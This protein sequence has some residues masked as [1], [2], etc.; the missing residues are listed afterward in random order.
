MTPRKWI[1]AELLKRN[2]NKA[3]RYA[4]L[5]E[6]AKR[7]LVRLNAIVA[8]KGFRKLNKTNNSKMLNS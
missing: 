3:T 2:M 5:R 1:D 7:Q 6:M 4:C 8:E